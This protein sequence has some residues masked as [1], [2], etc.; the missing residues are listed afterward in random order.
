[1]SKRAKLFLMV[2][3]TGM[4][5]LFCTTSFNGCKPEDKEQTKA[6]VVT[7]ETEP[8]EAGP[9]DMLPVLKH[10]KLKVDGNKIV[11][12]S[13]DP[14]QLRGMSFFWSQWIGK[15]YNPEVVKCLKDDWRCNIVRAALAVEYNGYLA[16]PESEKQKLKVVVD[17]AIAEGL[18]VIIDWHDHHAF[19]HTEEA[20]EFFA[21]MAQLYGEYPN[22]IYE[23]F[24]EPERVPWTTKVKPYHEAVI[25]T[26]R[27]YDPDN[28]IICGTPSWS[29][30]VNVAAMDPL[31][32]TNL[33]Y[34]LHFY[35]GT[36]KQS[37]RNKATAA[38][39]AGVALMVTE[40]GTTDATGDGAVNQSETRVWLEFLDQHKISWC[41]WSVGDKR[42]SSAALKPG[43]SANGGWNTS[44]LTTSGNF[45][46]NE[47]ISKNPII[48]QN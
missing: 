42:E 1:M 23:P 24:N 26:I 22:V 8:Q 11:N 37:L 17:A 33:A 39:N 9:P 18:Y 21:E 40:F 31:I 44:D 47:L 2:A 29:Q 15:Y 14:V 30:D 46:R 38:L 13:G 10:G 34:A 36:H 25:E 41:N 19:D 35:S 20:K 12:E 3:I 43:T 45:I 7:P 16:H 48:K 6:E 5:T 27:K 32:G 4:L 28:L